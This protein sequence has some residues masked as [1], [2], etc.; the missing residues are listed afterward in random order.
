MKAHEYIAKAKRIVLKIGS[1]LVTDQEKGCVRQDWLFELAKTISNDAGNGRQWIV[2]S[3]GATALG[4]KKIGI[5]NDRHSHEIR[6][7]KKQAA[8]GIGQITLA[9]AYKNAFEREKM[10]VSQIL[11]T[12]ADTENRRSHLNARTTIETLLEHGVLPVIN[13]NDTIATDQLRFGDN[14]RLAAR[15]SQMMGADLLILLSTTDGLY[16]DDPL[17]NKSAEHIG[18]VRE[19][20]EE[21]RAFSKTGRAGITTG[22]MK[23]KIMAAEIATESGCGVIIA[24][25]DVSPDPSGFERITYFHPKDTPANA[26]KRWIAAHLYSKGAVI[27]DTGAANALQNGKSL[28]PVGAKG[29]EGEFTRGDIVLIK[30]QAGNVIGRGMAAYDSHDAQLIL[31]KKTD[32]IPPVLGFTGRDALIHRDD[33]ALL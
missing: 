29:I 9:H 24:K 16:T 21:I 30:T 33:M 22:G 10:E 8:A 28:L 5:S 25:G 3:S 20:T 15:V 23:S 18:E 14:D 4:R 6:L 12:I 32:E 19:I 13:E 1:V 11:L 2:V 31:G 17:E 7:E 27:I 26:R